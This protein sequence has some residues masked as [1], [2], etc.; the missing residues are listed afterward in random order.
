MSRLQEIAELSREMLEECF[1]IHVEDLR[2]QME[3]HPETYVE[4]LV[5]AI[6]AAV[7]Q[8]VRMQR[9]QTKGPIAYMS[10]S[11]PLSSILMER[12]ALGVH[13]Y[14]EEW[15]LDEMEVWHTSISSRNHSSMKWR[16]ARPGRCPFSSRTWNGICRP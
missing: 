9:A 16:Y 11:L 5:H 10:F 3:E 15:F 6:Q 2:S 12:Y 8:A 7:D 14:G 1:A 4:P 13:L